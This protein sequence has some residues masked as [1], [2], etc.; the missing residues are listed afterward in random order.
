MKNIKLYI[1]AIL[2]VIAVVPKQLM[3]QDA[4]EKPRLLLKLKYFNVNNKAQYLLVTTKTKIEGKFQNVSNVPVNV[5]IT[6]NSKEHLLS[7]VKTDD[8]GQAIVFLTAK[9]QAEWNKMPLQTFVAEA[10]AFKKFD[11][12]STDLSV[13]KA[14]I[15]LDTLEG[16]IIT[17]KVLA[18]ND[19][20]WTPIAGVDMVVGAKRL[21]GILNAN[22]TPT[23]TTD[24]SG[25]V[26]AEFKRDSL[27]GD[28]KGKIVLT[29]AVLDND[30][31]GTLTAE[32]PANWGK[33][34]PYES[35]F[36]ERT[37]FARRGHSPI[38][39]EL[40]AYGI[41]VAVWGVLI[42]LALEIRKIMKLG[43]D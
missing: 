35:N 22:E 33:Y 14:K 12:A 9:A 32:L 15:Q 10:A 36:D 21:G 4:P 41:V 26:S 29:A 16:R 38:W 37:L 6:D 7:N 30:T 1:I 25:S 27:P 23:Y 2:L 28:V 40:L 5:F 13:T 42:Y 18:L 39:L 43:I 8:R 20:V 11:E 34:Y 31:Y 17:A 24:S 3:A 19:T